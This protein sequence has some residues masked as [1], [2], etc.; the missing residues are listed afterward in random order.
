MA[1]DKAKSY[2]SL[3]IHISKVRGL[4][5]IGSIFSKAVSVDHLL[6]L[7]VKQA[8]DVMSADVCVLK[9]LDSSRNRLR[10][11]AYAGLDGKKA[12]AF[13]KLENGMAKRVLRSGMPC[14]ISDAKAY[15]KN[16]LSAF[17]KRNKIHAALMV[18]LNPE[19]ICS[20]KIC[21]SN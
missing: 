14:V 3:R 9:L 2:E 16:K 5:G 1:A 11:A 20:E 12:R 15:Y 19:E 13:A 6:S 10:L 4:A 17:F 18:P 8:L 7:I 21:G